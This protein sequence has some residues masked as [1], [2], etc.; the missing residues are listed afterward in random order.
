MRISELQDALSVKIWSIER[1]P[2]N[3]LEVDT[4]LECFSGL[5]VLE[6]GAVHFVH[7]TVQEYFSERNTL[8]PSKSDLAKVCLTYASFQDFE[9]GPIDKAHAQMYEKR[10]KE[11]PLLEYVARNWQDYVK[12]P[13]E[14]DPELLKHLER[15]LLS[16]S[17]LDSILQAR[18]AVKRDGSWW[19]DTYPRNTSPL[20]VVAGAGLTIVAKILIRQNPAYMHFKNS[21]G[22]IPLH[23][24]IISSHVDTLLLLIG[25]NGELVHESDKE[26]MTALHHAAITGNKDAM[27]LLLEARADVTAEDRFSYTPLERA[28]MDS[29]QGESTQRL[30]EGLIERG[31]DALFK[32]MRST[33]WTVLHVASCLGYEEG[34]Q[35]LLC[36]GFKVETEDRWGNSALHR[37]AQHGHPMAVKLLLEALNG[38]LKP[39]HN[40][41]TPLHWASGVGQTE[42][43]DLLLSRSNADAV[44]RDFR[45][46][47]PLHWAALGGHLPIVQKLLPVTNPMLGGGLQGKDLVHLAMWSGSIEVIEYLVNSI[48]YDASTS[49]IRTEVLQHIAGQFDKRSSSSFL[50]IVGRH[51]LR[52]KKMHLASACFDL[53]VITHTTNTSVHI[54]ANISHPPHCNG[55]MT[56]PIKGF[57]YRCT[58]CITYPQYNLCASCFERKPMFAHAHD[59]YVQIPNSSTLPKVEE[60]L[61][62]LREALDCRHL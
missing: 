34:I 32:T 61:E 50:D 48:G 11:Y 21:Y 36:A 20:H 58:K 27:K 37:A 3:I 15:F 53:A 9:K 28:M 25:S 33:N 14:H 12:G 43:V 60:L 49:V 8:L 10:V 30:L 42:V 31:G 39:S 26:G 45:G 47:T 52:K 23:E 62:V 29:R 17:K 41:Y 19:I 35:K 18:Y 24:A 57:C 38:N 46:W 55:C 51:H 54:P 59:Q 40:G 16:R 1:D 4:L 44:V 5:V 2:D 6:S 56:K 13:G 7:Y 22:R